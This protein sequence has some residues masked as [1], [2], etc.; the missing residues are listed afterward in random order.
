MDAQTKKQ[1][2]KNPDNIRF[3]FAGG[4]TSIFR[5]GDGI[6]YITFYEPDLDYVQLH[7]SPAGQQPMPMYRAVSCVAVPDRVAESLATQLMAHARKS[8]GTA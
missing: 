2:H 6:N 8:E 7:P 5:S 3:T 1:R 4:T